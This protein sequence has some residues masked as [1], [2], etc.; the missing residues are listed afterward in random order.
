MSTETQAITVR[1]P[2]DLYEWLRQQAFDQRVS[3]AALV[4]DAIAEYKNTHDQENGK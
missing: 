2:R 1:L 4:T 3:Q